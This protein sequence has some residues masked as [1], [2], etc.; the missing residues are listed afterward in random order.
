MARSGAESGRNFKRPAPHNLDYSGNPR[1]KGNKTSY[2]GIIHAVQEE[3]VDPFPIIVLLCALDLNIKKFE[4]ADDVE[5]I[6]GLSIDQIVEAINRH[7]RESKGNG[8]AR[9]P[10]LS[11]QAIYQCIVPE[12]SR[13]KGTILRNPP[14][15][16]TA[17][18]KEGWIGD[19]QVNRENGTPY[20]GVEVKSEQQINLDM[21]RGIIR[22]VKGNNVDRYYILST[23]DMYIHPDNKGTIYKMV[24]FIRQT[25]G[26]QV[27]V[28]GLNRT[29]WYYL[30]LLENPDVFLDYYTQQVQGDLDVK[31]EHRQTW[32][33]ILRELQVNYK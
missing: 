9:L 7:Y 17:N 30:R 31:P 4:Y 1:G 15:R 33:S 28:N 20:E 5:T 26:C 13:Y 22:K 8:R 16:H 19:I 10:V 24:E 18:D 11:M 6:P 25:T 32:Y 21:I 3:N 27:I 14:N 12:V 2:L 23:S 29:L